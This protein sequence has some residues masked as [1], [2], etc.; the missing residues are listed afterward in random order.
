MEMW[1]GHSDLS[2][3]SQ[4]SAVEGITL[5]TMCTCM[6]S[7]RFFLYICIARL[8]YLCE[9]A[10]PVILLQVKA[11]RNEMLKEI[12]QT[13]RPPAALQ[14]SLVMYQAGRSPSQRKRTSISKVCGY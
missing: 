1:S 5:Q 13:Q 4:V 6:L 9:N 2:I 12:V 10:L 7:S 8:L 11:S 3:I 14:N